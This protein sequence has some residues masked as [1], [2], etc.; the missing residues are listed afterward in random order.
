MNKLVKLFF[1]G[2]VLSWQQVYACSCMEW[3]SAAKMVKSY[4]GAY[5]AFPV[6]DSI[7]TGENEDR[8]F[9]TSTTTKFSV[10]RDYKHN[11]AKEVTIGSWKFD[12]ASCG[13]D[14]KKNEGLFFIFA[15]KDRDG[16][17]QTSG[18]SVSRM[19]VVSDSKFLQELNNL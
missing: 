3:K 6:S 16:K 2:A 13:V 5:L 1:V 7:S 15:Y 9:E 4:E 14:F 12:G 10:V 18:C 19:D 8:P 17:L 11:S